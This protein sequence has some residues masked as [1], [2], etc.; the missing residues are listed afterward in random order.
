[1]K[2][3]KIELNGLPFTLRGLT[4]G[5][6]E[7]IADIV[8]VRAERG[9]LRRLKKG[10]YA[11]PEEAAACRPSADAIGFISEEVG[12]FLKEP[13][14]Q[15]ALYKAMLVGP[16]MYTVTDEDAEAVRLAAQDPE[17]DIGI[18]CK[19]LFADAFPKKATGP[20]TPASPPTSTDPEPSTGGAS[21]S[22]TPSGSTAGS[23]TT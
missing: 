5:V 9:W 10:L 6:K 21:S 2:V 14:G 16:P 4:N 22:A 11:D 12:A 8:R 7:E 23:G 17:S 15:K 20:T 13:E 1:M 18:V 3:Y 19:A